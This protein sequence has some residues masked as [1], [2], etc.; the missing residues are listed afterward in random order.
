MRCSN[1]KV[2]GVNYWEVCGG[3]GYSC[4]AIVCGLST[5]YVE[6]VVVGDTTYICGN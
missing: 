6:S 3:V 1:Y 4:T 5:S 2:C